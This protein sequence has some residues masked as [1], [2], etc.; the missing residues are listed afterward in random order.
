MCMFVEVYTYIRSGTR[1]AGDGRR[2]VSD[3]LQ[4]ARG[5]DYRGAIEGW[6]S[7]NNVGKLFEGVVNEFR[8]LLE[9]VPSLAYSL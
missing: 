8:A 7:E 6:E 3:F 9:P 5:K 1:I 2:K 4:E